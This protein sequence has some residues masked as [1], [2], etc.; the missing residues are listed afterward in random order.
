M[1]FILLFNLLMISIS[2][3]AEGI[4]LRSLQNPTTLK[5]QSTSSV[6]PRV[7]IYFKNDC[8]ACRAQVKDLKCLDKKVEVFLVGVYA[9]ESELRSEYLKMRTSFAAFYADQEALVKL[10]LQPEV[11]PQFLLLDK[12][13]RWQGVGLRSCATFR[14]WLLGEKT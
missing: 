6:A 8:V 5:F 2:G 1:R 7:V 4:V 14:H 10:N 3:H 13:R 12:E 9:S 11:T